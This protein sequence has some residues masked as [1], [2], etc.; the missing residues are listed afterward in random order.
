MY[1]L[2]FSLIKQNEKINTA[3]R[4]QYLNLL[5]SREYDLPSTDIEISYNDFF[6]NFNNTVDK[7]NLLCHRLDIIPNHSLIEQ[8][9]NRNTKNLKELLIYKEKF[10]EIFES[11]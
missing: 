6:V 10:K 1:W 5:L 11:L 2:D 7:Y 9:I 4:Q 3:T 8:L